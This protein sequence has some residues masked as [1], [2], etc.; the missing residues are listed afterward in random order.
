MRLVQAGQGTG[1]LDP[2]FGKAIL[3]YHVVAG[4]T[5]V[6]DPAALWPSEQA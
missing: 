1:L 4:S 5:T 2:T 6:P 3:A